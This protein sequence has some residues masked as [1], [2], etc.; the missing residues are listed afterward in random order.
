MNWTR[1]TF[2]IRLEVVVGS[3]CVVCIPPPPKD[4]DSNTMKTASQNLLQKRQKALSHHQG[5]VVSKDLLLVGFHHSLSRVIP[6]EPSIVVVPRLGVDS[7]VK[8]V[9]SRRLF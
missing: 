1:L 8:H 2:V 5:V 9:F 3:W 4:Y 7:R 6:D